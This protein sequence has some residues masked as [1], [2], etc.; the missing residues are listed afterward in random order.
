MEILSSPSVLEPVRL[1]SAVAH[2]APATTDAVANRTIENLIITLFW[3]VVLEGA[4]RKWVAPQ[5]SRYLFFL[6][7]PV[8]LLVYWQAMR[9]QALR[10]M[11]PLLQTG[12]AF[13]FVAILL[14]FV[15]SIT[16]G[17][18]R[19]LPVLAYGWRQ[20]F[21]YLPLPLALCAFFWFESFVY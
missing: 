16:F 19:L 17:D 6:R 12:I 9:L 4:L 20:Y 1:R 8:M 11:G 7:D 2:P 14:A 18:A 10:N 15:Q 21:F 5:Y 13:S 3:L